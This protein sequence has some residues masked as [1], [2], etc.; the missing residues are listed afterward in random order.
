MT[1]RRIWTR[2]RQSNH[3]RES[4]T[5][6]CSATDLWVQVQSFLGQQLMTAFASNGDFLINALDNLSGSADLI[7]LR[8]RASFSRPFDRVEELRL[9]ADAQ[10]QIAT[11]QQLE[12]ELDETERNLGEL[13]A[14]REDTNSTD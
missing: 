4:P 7:S 10:F 1:N 14:A 9:A 8:S 13:Q 11:E 2:H 6:T 5:S 12:A 3:D